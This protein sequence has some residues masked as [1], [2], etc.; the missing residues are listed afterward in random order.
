MRGAAPSRRHE[1]Q[2]PGRERFRRGPTPGSLSVQGGALLDKVREHPVRRYVVLRDGEVDYRAGTKQFV[3]YWR[4]VGPPVVPQRGAR[5]TPPLARRPRHIW[6]AGSSLVGSA[7]PPKAAA[8][9]YGTTGTV[10]P[11]DGSGAPNRS[12]D[13]DP[14]RRF[15]T[16]DAPWKSSCPFELPCRGGHFSSCTTPRRP[17]ARVAMRQ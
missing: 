15:R 17:A 2:V 12:A 13:F 6:R 4:V 8:T 7:A 14:D 5:K 9:A 11:E 3:D 16:P 10:A 1:G